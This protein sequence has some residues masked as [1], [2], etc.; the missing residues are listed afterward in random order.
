MDAPHFFNT[1]KEEDQEAIKRC[2]LAV[3]IVED[4]IKTYWSTLA[5]DLPQTIIGDV[6]GLF[7]QSRSYAP[8]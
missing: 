3:S 2:I 6:G 1:L 5:L 7:G 4:K 8:T